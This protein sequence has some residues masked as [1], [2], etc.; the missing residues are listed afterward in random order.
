VPVTTICGTFCQAGEPPLALGAVGA[1]RSRRTVLPA[2]GTAGD[3]ALAFAAASRVRNWTTVS[4]SAVTGEEPPE[5]AADQ[6]APLSREMRYWYPPTPLSASVPP[7]AS[8]AALPAFDQV[9]EPPLTV[10][11]V[12]AVRSIRTVLPAVGAAGAHAEELP[13]ASTARNWTTV[14]SSAATIAA[15]AVAGALQVSAPSVDMRTS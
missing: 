15:A 11:A 4:P 5:T 7:A 12:G 2:S 3:Q 8:T 6:V 10:G 1:V 9:I 13:A 14:S